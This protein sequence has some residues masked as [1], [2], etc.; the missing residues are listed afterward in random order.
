MESYRVFGCGIEDC[1]NRQALWLLQG[2]LMK[3]RHF[4]GVRQWLFYSPSQ[5]LHSLAWALCLCVY[6]LAAWLKA[7]RVCVLLPICQV[8]HLFTRLLSEQLS[9]HTCNM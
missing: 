8:A 4:G 2:K 5:I 6:T 9:K 7:L 1:L 3:E